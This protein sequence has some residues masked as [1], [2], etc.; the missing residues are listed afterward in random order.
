VTVMN[1]L[2]P[3]GL[4]FALFIPAVILLYL[5]KLKRVDMPISSTLLWRRSLED[6][7]ANT[8]FQKLRRNLLLLL[9]LAVISLL[10]LALAR[11]VLNLGGLQGQSFIVLI[12][13]SASMSATDVKPSRLEAAKRKAI[14]L[15]NDMSLG[16]RMMVVSFSKGAR[17]LSPF[18]QDKASLRRVIQA[19]PPTDTPTEVEEAFRIAASA[20]EVAV[21]PEVFVFSDGEFTIPSGAWS[22]RM[23]LRYVPVGES[24]ENAGIVDLVVRK[25]FT[26]EGR[27]EILV[28]IQN[29]GQQEREIY[30]DLWG[31]GEAAG[32][33]ASPAAAEPAELRTERKLMD[34]RKFT[35]GPGALNTII[36]KDPGTFPRKIDLLLDS[37]DA[38]VADNQAWALIP[39][40]KEI[41]ILLVTKG[42]YYLQRVLNLNPQAR[43]FVTTP[44]AFSRPETYDLIVFDSFSPPALFA[45]NYV[46]INQIPPLPEWSIGEEIRLPALVDWNRTH[47]LTRYL[48]LDNLVINQCRNIGIPA[49]AEVIA[50][51]RET[52]LIVAFQDQEIKGVV[53]A[54][55][56]YDSDW[57]LRVSYPIFFSNLVNW[58][59]AEAG[60]SNGM[61]KTGEILVLDPPEDL[62]QPVLLSPPPPLPE[63][64][65]MF[66]GT[67]PVYYDK[68]TARG[69]YEYRTGTGIR[70]LYA[71]NLLSPQESQ[72]APRPSLDLQ[73]TEVEGE[74]AAVAANREIWR[75]LALAALLVLVI[76]WFVYVKRA[77]YAY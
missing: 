2:A 53:I 48:N 31:E 70:K 7:K 55:D 9:Q 3:L 71:V 49:W 51:S 10:T 11:P 61:K 41:Q 25:D 56:I 14:E 57:P 46:F 65:F 59:H 47:P 42:N 13:H 12:D 68:T 20:A 58:F 76:E 26:L 36:F 67:A 6:L 18:D 43:L 44:A 34:S 37:P 52:P 5:L 17:V 32:A 38:L 24:G 73:G 60:L 74:T 69:I 40:E 16:D 27:Y 30:L 4:F 66:T 19:I 64:T 22:G 63:Q 72:I 45:G 35:L 75:N 15:V 21:N 28:G 54:F 29:F 77:K 8:P 50:E 1:L 62:R 33:I 39:Q 23:N